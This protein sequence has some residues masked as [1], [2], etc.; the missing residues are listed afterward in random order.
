MHILLFSRGKVFDSHLA[1]QRCLLAELSAAT[2]VYL[3]GS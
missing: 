2:P 3:E 1:Q